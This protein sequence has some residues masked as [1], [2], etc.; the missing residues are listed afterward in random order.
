MA[1]FITCPTPDVIGYA[2]HPVNIDN[3]DTLVKIDYTWT[4]PVYYVI[5]FVPVNVKWY[6]LEKKDR[7]ETFSKII[8]DNL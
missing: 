4:S 2:N 5:G 7:D 6:F 8:K 3:V 1:K